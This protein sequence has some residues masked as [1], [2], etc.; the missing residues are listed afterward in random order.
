VQYRHA[1]FAIFRHDSAQGGSMAMVRTGV[2]AWMLFLILGVSAAWAQSDTGEPPKEAD[3]SLLFENDLFYNA[4]HDYTNGTEF[5]YTTA[6]DKAHDWA[7]ALAEDL[8]FFTDSGDVRTRY[9][10][11]QTMFTPNDITLPDPPL[12]DRPYGGFLFGSVGVVGD[13]GT[14]LDQ[15][16]LT[17]GV[18][19]PAS[20][21]EETQ[22][23]VHAIVQGRKPNGWHYQ[24]RDEPGLVIQYERTVKFEDH[25]PW[26]ALSFDAE[27][28]FGGAIGNVWDYV[29]AGG[30]ARIGFNIPEDYGPMR[31]QPSLPG[32]DY[33]E[34]SGDIG[35]YLFA[36]VEGRALA[37]NLFLDGNSFEASRS[38]VKKNLVGDIV[39][40][41]AL[42]FGHA[43]LAF[44]HVIRSR[45]Y[46]TQTGDDQFGAVDITLRF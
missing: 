22:K 24:L 20:L 46:E 27:P 13:N 16:Q 34:P 3:F 5:S 29:N 45:E 4:D 41:A 33:F 10:L 30:I 14:F 42:V 39:T 32:S 21:T 1:G 38:V 43:R 9:A 28:H 18:T 12:N 44:T 37:R 15:A 17:F 11:G 2:S 6:P 23:F 7:V 36:G 40:G 19:G 25:E 31:I 35:A 26:P 8:P